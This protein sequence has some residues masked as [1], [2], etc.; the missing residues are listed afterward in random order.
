LIDSV[1]LLQAFQQFS[2]GMNVSSPFDS[3][4]V[5]ILAIFYVDDG[6]PGVNDTL[7]ASALPLQLLLRQAE[8][9]TQSWERLLF[10]SGGALPG[11][12][13]EGD[14]LATRVQFG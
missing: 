3:L 10:A 6:M 4:L 14:G 7:E 2:P 5:S 8:Q 12:T 9:A 13:P 1:S 11:G